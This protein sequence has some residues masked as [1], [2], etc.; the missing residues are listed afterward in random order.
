MIVVRLQTGKLRPSAE[1][2]ERIYRDAVFNLG[3]IHRCFVDIMVDE[4]LLYNAYETNFV[5][6][7]QNGRTLAMKGDIDVKF[8]DRVRGDVGMTIM[9]MFG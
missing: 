1:K 7:V 2:P 6:D 9:V 3:K 5:V 8:S 4:Y